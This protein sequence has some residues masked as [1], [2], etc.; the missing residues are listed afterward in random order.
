MV[1]IA[2]K[3][4][5]SQA[6]FSPKSSPGRSGIAAAMAGREQQPTG[7]G[8]ELDWAR[9]LLDQM[10]QRVGQI[11][12]ATIR[13]RPTQ[14][15]TLIRHFEAHDR[16]EGRRNRAERAFELAA[17]AD[18]VSLAVFRGERGRGLCRGIRGARLFAQGGEVQ[19]VCAVRLCDLPQVFRLPPSACRLDGRAGRGRGF[20]TGGRTC[21]LDPAAGSQADEVVEQPQ[22]RVRIHVCGVSRRC[23]PI[24]RRICRVSCS[25][26]RM[27]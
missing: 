19:P 20:G 16:E 13:G 8:A 3:A 17:H 23:V 2:A 27:R 14:C 12:H 5:A 9:L 21:R 10:G 24:I 7:G 22:D 15:L 4:K 26:A 18:A 11:I 6:T 1:A 25:G